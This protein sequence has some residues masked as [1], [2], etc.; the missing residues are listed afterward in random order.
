MKDISPLQSRISLTLKYL[1][2]PIKKLSQSNITQSCHAFF[3][4]FSK[5]L[6]LVVRTS[7]FEM[8]QVNLSCKSFYFTSEMR[9]SRDYLQRFKLQFRLVKYVS[10]GINGT[11]VF[12]FR[13]DYS[14][15]QNPQAM[16]QENSIFWIHV[17]KMRGMLVRFTLQM[18]GRC[19]IMAQK[20]MWNL[21]FFPSGT[22]HVIT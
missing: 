16:H 4:V 11:A 7:G 20:R 19:Y 3:A 18:S 21:C 22:N 12:S 8:R 9:F 6:V 14:W 15:H 1:I 10:V 13:S 5:R 17:Y 2:V